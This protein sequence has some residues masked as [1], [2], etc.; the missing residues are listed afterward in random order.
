MVL[1]MQKSCTSLWR[2]VKAEVLA[3]GGDYVMEGVEVT[4]VVEVEESVG[5]G[6]GDG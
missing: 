5:G 4:V 2:W 6:D 1:C 3:G